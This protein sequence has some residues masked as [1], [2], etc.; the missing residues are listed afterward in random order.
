[1]NHLVRFYEAFYPFPQFSWGFFDPFF[2]VHVIFED[3]IVLY[4]FK[5]EFQILSIQL[6]YEGIVNK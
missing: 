3:N 1:M 2:F 6:F 4:L 5:W